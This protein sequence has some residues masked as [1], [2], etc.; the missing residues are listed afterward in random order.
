[1]VLDVEA[2]GQSVIVY[3]ARYGRRAPASAQSHNADHLA[4]RGDRAAPLVSELQ[5]QKSRFATL[6]ALS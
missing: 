4:K 3:T 1:M 6:S 5:D 2:L